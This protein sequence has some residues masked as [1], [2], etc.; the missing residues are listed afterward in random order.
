[1]SDTSLSQTLR[2]PHEAVPAV[3]PE[4]V[5]LLV[6]TVAICFFSLA[7]P[8]MTL[9]VY[10]R[11]L[12]NPDSGTLPILVCGV[13]LAIALEASLRLMRGYM[14]ARTGIV[15]EHKTI[16]ETINTLLNADLS[17][18]S[19]LG[20]GEYLH[21]ISAIAKLKDFY[22]GAT[23]V[24]FTE[25]AFV[26]F[27]LGLIVYIAG[28]LAIVPTVI[29][30]MFTAVS[31]WQGQRLR[32]TLEKRDKADDSRYNFL[33]ESLKGIHTIKA[34]A[35]EKVFAR[36]YEK[37]E[38][39]SS[40]ADYDVV[41][42]TSRS[43]NTGAL[44]SHMM[45]I[46]TIMVGA[47]LVLKG[48]ITTGALIASILLS[49]RM[50]QPLQRGLGL[51]TKYQDFALSRAKVEGL[52]STPQNR[53]ITGMPEHLQVMRA[54]TQD[55]ALALDNICF[56]YNPND[57]Y[58]FYNLNERISSG[59]C[60]LLD[61]PQG[62][63]KTTLM[64]LMAGLFPAEDGHVVI[65]GKNI[66]AMAPQ[67]LIRAAGYIG[68][69]GHTFRGTIRDNITGFSQINEAH[70]RE[71][72]AWLRVDRDIAKLPNGY[73]TIL[74]GSAIDAIAPGLKQRIAITRTLAARPRV[75]IFDNADRDLDRE[76]YN[77]VYALL[78]RLK[79]EATIIIASDDMNLHALAD[80][81]L[82][83]KNQALEAAP[84]DMYERWGVKPFQRLNFIEG[85]TK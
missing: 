45:L 47:V 57:P 71:T 69:Q 5:A 40:I 30:M 41:S 48:F 64:H 11:I 21:N 2:L 83:I 18:I 6:S 37:M 56:R 55:I 80:R 16:C 76:G 74:Q 4:T 65:D 20:A 26:P 66:L 61:G 75:I 39:E 79:S 62:S 72:A 32:T 24:T 36:R 8:V 13:L 38:A 15:Y 31:L 35:Q 63:G 78:A 50:L 1:M 33:I 53:A 84:H 7:V 51:W 59:E 19:R 81:K 3:Q 77:L 52:L 82:V 22:N 42:E 73:D 85:E 54:E 58:L 10:D 27:F 44:F 34:C 28:P 14:L 25:M 12:P 23:L 68:Q 49:G 9:Q 29:L 67:E 43:Y 46:S 60:I 70:A 17:R